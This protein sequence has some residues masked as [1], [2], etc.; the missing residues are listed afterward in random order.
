LPL[1]IDAGLDLAY[2]HRLYGTVARKQAQ[3]YVEGAGR[4]DNGIDAGLSL[5]KL[6]LFDDRALGVFDGL[7]LTG[8]LAYTS[9]ASTDALYTYSNLDTTIGFSLSF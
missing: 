7:S 5:N 6:I 3:Q 2:E 9:V 8:G 1:D 4:T